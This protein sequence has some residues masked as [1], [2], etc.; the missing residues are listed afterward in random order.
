M[1]KSFGSWQTITQCR[2]M[3]SGYNNIDALGLYVYRWYMFMV[4][5][6]GFTRALVIVT[7]NPYELML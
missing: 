4:D 5:N 6:A 7:W 2:S 3:R 1:N